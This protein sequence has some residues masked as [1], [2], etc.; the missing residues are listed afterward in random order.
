MPR[1]LTFDEKTASALRGQIAEQQIFEH[2]ATGAVEYA[3]GSGRTMVAVIPVSAA[4]LAAVAVFRRPAVVPQP[5]I[6][7]AAPQQR[8][9]APQHHAPKASSTVRAGGFLGLSDEAAYE[10][11][12]RPQKKQGWFK[13]NFWP[14]DE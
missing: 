10:E 4:H 12:P 3:L 14:E 2:A 7:R 1:Y 9:S 5:P 11:E 6:T 13:K 8:T